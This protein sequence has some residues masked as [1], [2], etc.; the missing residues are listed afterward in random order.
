MKARPPGRSAWRAARRPVHGGRPDRN[1]VR[2][3]CCCVLGRRAQDDGVLLAGD[4]CARA[5]RSGRRRGYRSPWRQAVNVWASRRAGMPVPAGR[6]ATAVIASDDLGLRAGR[7]G[8]MSSVRSPVTPAVKV[9]AA[10]SP[11]V[12]GVHHVASA[13]RQSGSPGRVVL[14][15]GGP[16]RRPRPAPGRRP[17]SAPRERA[18]ERAATEGAHPG[19]FCRRA[20]CGS[21]PTY[22]TDS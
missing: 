4:D 5:S 7:A 9:C 13:G 12:S 19:C 2:S 3:R 8:A 18:I 14:V 22:Q 1:P 16:G 15:G 20:T 21:N 10:Q 17:V 11:G 6:R